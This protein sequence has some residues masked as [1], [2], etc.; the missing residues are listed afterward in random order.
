MGYN[1]SFFIN[2]YGTQPESL[3]DISI[4]PELP[5]LEEAG[6]IF[7]GWYLDEDLTTPAEAGME[8]NSDITL[9]ASWARDR[10]PTT[11][12][13]SGSST[14]AMEITPIEPGDGFDSLTTYKLGS[15]WTY[16]SAG[17]YLE[18]VLEASHT[19]YLNTEVPIG[20]VS[21]PSFSS[22]YR[23]A[24]FKIV[25][26]PAN[27][28]SSTSQS[29]GFLFDKYLDVQPYFKDD[30]ATSTPTAVGYKAL[31]AGYL[32]LSP[33]ALENAMTGST[34]AWYTKAWSASGKVDRIYTFVRTE[35]FLKI[36]HKDTTVG[37]L[38]SL[39]NSSSAN[40]WTLDVTWDRT[41]FPANKIPYRLY[42]EIQAGGG[43]GGYGGSGGGGGGGAF[44]AGII[45]CE[46]PSVVV[47]LCK[48]GL[49]ANKP[50]N[51]GTNGGGATVGYI[52][53]PGQYFSFASGS[54]L[55][56]E[57]GKKGGTSAYASNNTS[58]HAGGNV[59]TSYR[60]TSYYWTQAA[61][62]G[63]AG[64][65]TN[66]AGGSISA[67]QNWN[68]AG[69]YSPI[70]NKF[71]TN[72]YVDVSY[73]GGAGK[74]SGGGGGGG[75]SVLGGGADGQAGTFGATTINTTTGY[76]GG[77]GGG[78]NA[79]KTPGDGGNWYIWISY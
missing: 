61:I 10:R 63:A 3:T 19:T 29:T 16:G 78:G 64:G 21:F 4:L 31:K 67:G 68:M 54:S 56:I 26:Y 55:Y 48:P 18:D 49:W 52:Y 12:E 50:D 62:S 20:N 60:N 57:G 43:S 40:G 14:Y 7:E 1:V 37:S 15:S 42:V 45:N 28:V 79:Q 11:G 33:T 69:G 44:W 76:G 35:T 38:T 66:T 77:G 36:Y 39:P 13:D 32:P 70:S 30:N 2:G 46:T 75:G 73:S 8:V 59:G 34:A 72:R 74:G 27:L 65:K 9:Y 5:I 23:L 53:Q 25:S 58:Y 22:D 51:N 17:T 24:G 47:E 6:F 71:Y 41:G